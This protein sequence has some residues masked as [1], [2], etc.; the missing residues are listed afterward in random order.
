MEKRL[1]FR[2]FEGE[3]VTQDRNKW[4]ALVI[5]LVIIRVPKI[6]GNFLT[7]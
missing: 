2:H 3:A 4:R 1:E 6:G 5:V 7:R